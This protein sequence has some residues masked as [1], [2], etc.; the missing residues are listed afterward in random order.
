MIAVVTA[1]TLI[2][3]IFYTISPETRAEVR[4]ALAGAD[5]SVSA[6]RD[7]PLPVSRAPARRRRQPG[8]PAAERSTAAR[9]RDAVGR[10]RWSLIIYQPV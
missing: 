5:D 1:S 3:Y 4:H 7:L 10:S 6:V 9:L 8:R 2:A